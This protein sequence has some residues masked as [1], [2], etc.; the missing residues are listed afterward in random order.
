MAKTT[1]QATLSAVKH[2]LTTK[3]AKFKTI[4]VRECAAKFGISP[5]TLTRAL[6]RF[7]K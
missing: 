3:Q 2:Y 5:S 6:K 7:K 1:S 4:T